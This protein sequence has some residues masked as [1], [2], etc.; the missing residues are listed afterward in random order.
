MDRITVMT[1]SNNDTNLRQQNYT[2]ILIF[3][4]YSVKEDVATSEGYLR[5]QFVDGLSSLRLR[6]AMQDLIGQ[7]HPTKQN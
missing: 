4:Y 1:Q 5:L 6:G 2:S 3:R 7:D